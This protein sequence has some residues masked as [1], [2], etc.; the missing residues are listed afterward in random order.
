MA[1]NMFFLDLDS[2]KKLIK[3]GIHPRLYPYYKTDKSFFLSIYF[4][5]FLSR[6]LSYMY[7]KMFENLF[8]LIC[9][10]GGFQD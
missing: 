3:N 8:V 6:S 7:L 9:I 4:H 10:S 5:I 1:W 2:M